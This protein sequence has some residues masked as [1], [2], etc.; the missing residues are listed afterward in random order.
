MGEKP[1]MTLLLIKTKDGKVLKASQPLHIMVAEQ[2]D[3][4]P[5]DII[6]VGFVTKSRT[7]WCNRAPH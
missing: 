1:K 2:F 5:E 4:D 7:V 6:D 3:I